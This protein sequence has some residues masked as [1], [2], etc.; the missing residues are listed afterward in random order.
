VAAGTE[1]HPDERAFEVP[2]YVRV[3]PPRDEL[4]DELRAI[5][6]RGTM[7]LYVFTGG[8]D[9]YNHEG[10]HRGAFRDVRFGTLMTERHLRA[11]DHIITDLDL[12]RQAVD[13]HVAWAIEVA[14]AVSQRRSP[15]SPSGTPALG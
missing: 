11:S 9:F 13:M 2:S 6:R 14:N 4:A 3:I 7:L 15:L 8:L 1:V 12:Q 5:V 10:Q